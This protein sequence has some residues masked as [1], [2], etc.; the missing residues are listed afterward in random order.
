M[1]ASSNTS[2]TRVACP[3]LSTNV[4]SRTD[5][6]S[7]P[8]RSRTSPSAVAASAFGAGFGGSVWAMVQAERAERFRHDWEADY[9]KQFPERA[10]MAEFFVTLPGPAAI[11]L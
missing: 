1:A 6:A 9:W 11:R 8:S 7:S 3:A 2:P 5:A 10:D 4:L